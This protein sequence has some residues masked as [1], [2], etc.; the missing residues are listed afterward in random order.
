VGRLETS[1][2]NCLR[3]LV[4]GECSATLARLL[5][6][7]A[8]RGPAA[9]TACSALELVTRFADFAPELLFIDADGLAPAGLAA[10]RTLKAHPVTQAVPIIV[11]G[12][13]VEQRLQAFSAGADDFVTPTV[14]R[15]GLRA[16]VE[17]LV[18]AA[19]A[20]RTLAAT[21]QSAESQELEDL[22][23]T[24]RRYL[25]P[26]L[27]DRILADVDLRESLLEQS[28]VRTH[29][30]VLFADMRG[31]TTIS[32]R[33]APTQVVTLLNEY[34]SLLTDIAFRHDGT[35][36][37]M[38]GDCLMVGFGVPLP[39]PDSLSRAIAA[40]QEMLVCFQALS[41]AWTRRHHV[42][43]GLGIG[44][45]AGEVV[46]GNIGSAVYMNYTIIGDA[47]N[48]AS[49]LCQ[50]ARAGEMLF[51]ASVKQGLDAL[52][53]AVG[54]VAL[55]RIALRGRSNPVDVF[56]IPLPTRHEAMVESAVA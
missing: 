55:P 43:T 5:R 35:V 40:G 45:N 24:F 21:R 12:R 31:F 6:L 25:S 17:A 15:E 29:A 48:V 56:C 37:S 50:R 49:R 26:R 11:F 8:P 14:R 32:E 53:L 18:L 4:V 23:R 10:C 34:F 36:F 2:E 33:L 30:V 41:E 44:V 51:S 28:N 9:L 13:T 3:A 46:A 7:A 38:A 19:A 47:V 20:R 54:A 16:R 1:T 39:Q 22:R 27:A 42:E 52:G